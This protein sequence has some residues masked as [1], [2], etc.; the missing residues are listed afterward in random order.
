VY[1]FIQQ[2]ITALL[3]DQRFSEILKGSVWTLSAQVLATALGL[4]TTVII[5][6]MYGA[7]ILGIVA[8]LQSFFLLATILTVMG[9]NTS[10]LRLIPEY[11]SR[12]S[13]SAAFKV[14]RNTQYFVAGMSV[15]TGI[16]VF[17]GSGFI[18]GTVFS[19]PH[20]QQ[21]FSLAAVFVFFNSL[22]LLNQQ[23]VRGLRLIKGFAFLQMLPQLS[24][25]LILVPLTLFFF[26]PDNPVYALYASFTIT[27]LA[28]IWL[29]NR[30]F[31]QKM[32]PDD[33][34]RPLP[35]KQIVSL[36]LPM[37]MTST[38]TFIIGQTGV[39][40]L[41]MFRPEAEAGYYSIAVKLATLTGFILYAVNSMAGPRFSELYHS[42]RLDE[43]F[44]VAKKSAKLIF[45]TTTPV[46]LGFVLL[47]K[48]ILYFAFGPE[49]VVAYLP[50]VLLVIGQFVHSVSGATG[51]FMNMTGHQKVF[52]NIVFIA[53]VSNIG[54]NILLT[55]RYGIYGAAVAA[56]MTLAGWNMVTLVFMKRKFGKTTGYFPVLM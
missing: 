30:I 43:L 31:R 28:G 35:I 12:Y 38:M 44:Y 3:S 11:L 47:G 46:L 52:R 6:R 54:I 26:H 4:V 42:D 29:V 1:H 17:F 33:M 53:A 21:Y 24:K 8:V 41:G 15:I 18:A 50:L 7:D 16:A 2:K 48:P 19:K 40:M 10:I 22:M 36:S 55:P 51:L 20:L 5:A 34:P 49:Y 37:L 45:W 23:A 32:S 9:T 56:M 14:Y 27:A 25:L 39:I 13:A